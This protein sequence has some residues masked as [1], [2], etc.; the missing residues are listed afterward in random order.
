ML[1]HCAELV[2]G[3]WLVGGDGVGGVRGSITAGFGRLQP[4]LW[5][6]VGNPLVL[7]EAFVLPRFPLILTGEGPGLALP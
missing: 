3:F 5:L 6:G 7:S 2:L 1:L 4:V